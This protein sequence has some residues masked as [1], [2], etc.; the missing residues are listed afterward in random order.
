MR[1]AASIDRIVWRVGLSDEPC[2]RQIYERFPV[3]TPSTVD[4]D[5]FRWF[6]KELWPRV[7]QSATAKGILIF[8]RSSYDF[9]RLR[10]FFRKEEVPICLNSEYLQTKEMQ[11]AEAHF[12][13]GRSRFM[14]YTERAH[15]YHRRHIKG[16]KDLVFYSLPEYARYYME[17]LNMVE[18]SDSRASGDCNVMFSKYDRMQLDRVVGTTRVKKMMNS[19][20]STFVFC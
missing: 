6:C 18:E 1:Q 17:L 2:V 13:A 5:R 14:L 3:S 4:D 15:F 9:I 12:C 7:H 20:N 10:N 8:V 19:K 16:V 11:S